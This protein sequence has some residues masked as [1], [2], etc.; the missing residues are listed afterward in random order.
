MISYFVQSITAIDQNEHHMMQLSHYDRD[1]TV[2]SAVLCIS[3][4][5][6]WQQ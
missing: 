1:L 6:S 5:N 2:P 3:D 4:P